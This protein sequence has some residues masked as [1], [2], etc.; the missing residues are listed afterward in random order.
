MKRLAF[1]A[2]LLLSNFGHLHGQIIGGG[3]VAQRVITGAGVPSS[4]ACNTDGSVGKVY[5]NR[6]AAAVFSSFYT[7]DKTGASTYAWELYGGT[8]ITAGGTNGVVYQTSGGGYQATATGGA[9]TLCL[10]SVSG[11]VPTFSSCAGSASTAP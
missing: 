1:A 2:L 10:V 8:G 4:S 7:C 9:G 5:I 3:G 11:G 6:T